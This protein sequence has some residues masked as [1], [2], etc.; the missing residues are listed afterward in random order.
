MGVRASE[1]PVFGGG[2]VVRERAAERGAAVERGA[3]CRVSTMTNS[4]TPDSDPTFDRGR[5]QGGFYLVLP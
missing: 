4:L 2:A 1:V 3:E 5:R